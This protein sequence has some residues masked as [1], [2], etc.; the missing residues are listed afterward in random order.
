MRDDLSAPNLGQAKRD[1]FD[2]PF[3]WQSYH[4][5]EQWMTRV[6]AK[7]PLNV[8]KLTADEVITDKLSAKAA[9][10]NGENIATENYVNAGDAA[11]NAN[12]DTRVLRAG[13][14]MTGSLEINEDLTVHGDTLINGP[15][16]AEV[17]A[18]FNG[19]A[20]FW[21]TTTTIGGDAV[22]YGHITPNTTAVSNLGSATK[23]WGTV[24]TSDLSLKNEHG[25]W[26]IVE[27]ADDLFITNNRT[28]KKYK[29]AL[30]EVD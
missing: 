18:E 4:T 24:Y 25:D 9:N 11:A 7:G 19:N 26:T 14:I 23:R 28:G 6:L 16:I 20:Q 12:A 29:F 13:D 17:N 3:F 30:V 22:V 21:N 15:F 1:G 27:G 8:T 5:I 10:I 2:A